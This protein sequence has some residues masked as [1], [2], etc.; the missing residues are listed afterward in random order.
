LQMSPL[1][2]SHGLS[3]AFAPTYPTDQRVLVGGATTD[4]SDHL[5][6]SVVSVCRSSTCDDPVSLPGADGVPS[7]L[8]SRSFATT[9]LAFAWAGPHLYRSTDGGARFRALAPPA[10]AGVQALAEGDDGT[11][12]AALL[13]ADADGHPVGGL[14]VS[15]DAG[16]TWNRLGHDTLLEK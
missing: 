11:L 7:L 8:V 13:G 5:Q 6:S 12:Y 15:H 9:G 14:F 2:S 4:D 3:F 10:P 1:P 16:R